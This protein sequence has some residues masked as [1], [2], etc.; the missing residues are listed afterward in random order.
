MRH[1][2]RAAFR[3]LDDAQR[4]RDHEYK[5]DDGWVG[6]NEHAPEVTAP[7]T[8]PR[9]GSTGWRSPAAGPHARPWR[10]A[11]RRFVDA[12]WHPGQVA[13]QALRA[14][15]RMGGQRAPRAPQRRRQ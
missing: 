2:D 6:P 1:Y 8:A 7:S 14:L 10:A 5:A 15:R 13:R 3:H 11:V 12:I 4:Y 9:G